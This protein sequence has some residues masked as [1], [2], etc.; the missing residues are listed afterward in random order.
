VGDRTATTARRSWPGGPTP[1]PESAGSWD[2]TVS[3]V[4]SPDGYSEVRRSGPGV[5]DA[6]SASQTGVS[7]EE[8][9]RTGRLSGRPTRGRWRRRGGTALT[10]VLL[11]AA[12]AVLW[13]RLHH[14]P[15]AV[16]GVVITSQVKNGCA[17]NV[18]GRIDTTGGAGSVSYQWVFTPQQAAPVPLSQT[19]TA[20]QSSVYVTV[21]DQGVGQGQQ[22]QQVTLQVLGP[23]QGSASTHVVLSC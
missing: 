5:P 19:V 11:I 1:R 7:A 21:A 16:T 15:L 18:T 9:W 17:V 12:G 3:G 4:Q 10:V 8:V 14:A 22:A 20:G 23:G 6:A 13:L 2:P